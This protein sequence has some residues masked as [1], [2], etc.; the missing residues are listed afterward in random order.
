MLRHDTCLIAS[1]PPRPTELS[2]LAQA[3]AGYWRLSQ[4]WRLRRE[5]MRTLERLSDRTLK[6]IGI[7]RSQIESVA[8]EQ[9]SCRR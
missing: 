8:R 7:D 5:T 9:G 6:D 1:S 3:I 4:A 2:P